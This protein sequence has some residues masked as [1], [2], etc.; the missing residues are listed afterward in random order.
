MR[1]KIINY[2]LLL[3][4][5]VFYSCNPAKFIIDDYTSPE[6][7][8]E[9]IRT[10]ALPGIIGDELNPGEKKVIEQKFLSETKLKYKDVAFFE[11]GN[12]LNETK[13]PDFKE[14]WTV[15]WDKYLNANIVDAV[16]LYD[17]SEIIK[18]N[19]ILQIALIDV[20][21]IFGE[22]R[23]TVGQTTV[24]LKLGLFSLKSGKLLWEATVSGTQAN[25]HSDQVIPKVIEA[26]NVAVTNIVDKLPFE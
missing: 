17:V 9:V 10:I 22:H 2:H 4:T 12:Y 23:K 8:K 3:V 24:K 19:A 7:K 15:F 6:L 13:E 5:I 16:A 14:T 20:E 25:A 1:I 11:S 21:K 18:T 26:V